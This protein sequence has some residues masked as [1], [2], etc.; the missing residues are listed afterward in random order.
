MDPKESPNVKVFDN[1]R[2]FYDAENV[3]FDTCVFDA[4][5][6]RLPVFNA[7]ELVFINCKFIQNSN[8]NFR[9]IAIFKGTTQFL[10]KGKGKIDASEG[11]FE[12]KVLLIIKKLRILKRLNLNKI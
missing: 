10:M 3:V 5:N 2:G 1:S 6:K 11:T 7:K 8:E 4:V 9:D 12:G